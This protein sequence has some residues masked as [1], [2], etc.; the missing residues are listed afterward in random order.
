MSS[1]E[2]RQKGY[3]N[4]FVHDLEVDFKIRCRRNKLLGLWA[5]DKMGMDEDDAG[6][7]AKEVVDSTVDGV[8]NQ[9]VLD[10]ISNDLREK[11]LNVEE[12]EVI[13]EMQKL[14]L[15]AKEEYK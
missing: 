6:K 13:E 7:Y 4:K 5:A 12:A 14:L 1:F 11:G 3:E 15:A 9:T 10:K 2:E 8:A